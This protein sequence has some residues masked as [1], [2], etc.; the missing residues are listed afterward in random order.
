MAASEGLTPLEQMIEALAEVTTSQE[1]WQAVQGHEE[2][3]IEKAMLFQDLSHRYQ[4]KAW[5]EAPVPVSTPA[6][7]LNIGNLNSD[8]GYDTTEKTTKGGIHT[9]NNIYISSG[10]DTGY[11]PTESLPTDEGV[12]TGNAG[13]QSGEVAMA[14]DSKETINYYG[15]LL[16]QGFEDGI[17]TFKELLKPWPQEERWGAIMEFERLAPESMERLVA[18]APNWFEWCDS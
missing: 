7:S 2:E 15:Q 6:T 4:L 11:V 12:A 1:F 3:E 10:V 8:L 18:I 9:G 17:E 14:E 13:Y 5:Y 16:I